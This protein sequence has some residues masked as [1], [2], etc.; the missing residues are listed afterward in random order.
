VCQAA[1]IDVQAFDRIVV[2][3]LRA[4]PYALLKPENRARA[5]TL[6]QERASI[7]KQT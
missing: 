5:K 6:V 2:P 4:Q 3:A 1:V 7:P